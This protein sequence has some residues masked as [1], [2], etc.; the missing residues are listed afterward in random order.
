M[1]A[2]HS[3]IR[4][5]LNKILASTPARAWRRFKLDTDRDNFPECEPCGGLWLDRKILEKRASRRFQSDK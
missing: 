2:R 1:S 5:R 3:G 4:D